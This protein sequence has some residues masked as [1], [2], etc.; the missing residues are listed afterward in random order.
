MISKRKPKANRSSYTHKVGCKTKLVQK[1]KEELYILL[2]GTF[3]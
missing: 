1:D 2:K 3:H